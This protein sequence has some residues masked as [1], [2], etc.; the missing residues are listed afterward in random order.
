MPGQPCPRPPMPTFVPTGRGGRGAG[1]RLRRG[2]LRAQGVKPLGRGG[3]QAPGQHREDAE[4]AEEA[5]GAAGPHGAG[6]GP[7]CPGP[8]DSAHPARPLPSAPAALARPPLLSRRPPRRPTRPSP[9]PAPAPHGSHPAGLSTHGARA[10][11]APPAGGE[12]AAGDRRAGS[13]EQ[14]LEPRRGG[15]AEKMLP[16]NEEPNQRGGEWRKEPARSGGHWPQREQPGALWGLPVPGTGRG[17]RS[18]G[19]SP[20][21]GAEGPR[22]ASGS[23]SACDTSALRCVQSPRPAAWQRALRLAGSVRATLGEGSPAPSDPQSRFHHAP[24]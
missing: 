10:P 14:R 2:V 16:G 3:R 22:E 11:S 6:S 23:C 19:L 21:D 4:G 8:R 20:G 13:Q 9:T 15:A 24:C 18:A 17:W 12:G 5:L 1:A 7:G